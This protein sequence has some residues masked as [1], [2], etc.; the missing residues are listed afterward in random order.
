MRQKSPPE[1]AERVW[2]RIGYHLQPCHDLPV[3]KST[4]VGYSHAFLVAADAHA[5]AA[6]ASGVDGEVDGMMC[7][8][9]LQNAAAGAIKVLG[10]GDPAVKAYLAQSQHLKEVRG[11]FTHF[12]EYALGTG[13]LQKSLDGATGPFGWMVMWNSDETFLI[14]NR[15][16][17]QVL[18]IK[19][20]VNIHSAL[21]AV[22]VLVA[23]AA[24]KVNKT[25]SPLLVKLTSLT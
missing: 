14:L 25:P 3:S 23:A 6:K 10:K 2:E 16:N 20:E 19:Y 17:G 4:M 21:T 8:I 13:R 24:V 15:R 22:A 12:D 5:D 11:M 1:N 9:A 7:V 18:P